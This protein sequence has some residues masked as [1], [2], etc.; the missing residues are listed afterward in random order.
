MIFCDNFIKN[1]KKIKS[2]N[3]FIE[4]G[5]IVF[6]GLTIH[7]LPEGLAIGS[8]FE[9]STALGLS[10]AIAICIHDIPEGISIAL[11][12][13]QG[14]ASSLKSIIITALSGITTGIGAFIGAIISN[15]SPNFVSMSLGFAAGAML[16]IVSCELLPES[17]SM[18]KGRFPAI[19][20]II[21]IILGA[22]AHSFI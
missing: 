2:Q 18:Y 3:K 12:L 15:I 9:T 6:L 16:Y 21:G 11:P 8:G 17:K 19:G 1:S 7:N 13:K 5:I 22:L 4:T 14:G 20:N 10:L